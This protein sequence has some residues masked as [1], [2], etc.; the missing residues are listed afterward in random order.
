MYEIEGLNDA[1]LSSVESTGG[2]SILFPEFGE[3]GTPGAG[4]SLLQPIRRRTSVN[5]R[6]IKE[7]NFKIPIPP[8]LFCQNSTSSFITVEKVFSARGHDAKRNS[9][10]YNLRRRMIIV[11]ARGIFLQRV[12]ESIEN[13]SEYFMSAY[14]LD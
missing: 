4:V 11:A 1:L 13:S 8:K 9:Y 14:V 12:P 6:I 3:F 2:T 10:P 5:A 7:V